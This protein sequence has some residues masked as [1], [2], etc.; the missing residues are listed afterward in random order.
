[1]RGII[2]FGEKGSGK[3]TAA[4]LISS[5]SKK[6]SYFF[7]I[8][9]IVRS[10]SPVF[11]ATDKW[12][13]NKRGF[14][15]DIAKKLKEYDINFLNLFINGKILEKFNCNNFE[16]IKEDKLIIITGGR[17]DEDFDYWKEKG[18]ITV[19]IHCDEEIRQER[20]KNRDGY[21]QNTVDSLEEN[22]K[23]NIKRSDFVIDNSSTKENLENQIATF[24]R[25]L[26][27]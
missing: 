26:Y 3:D 27:R 9:D 11:K 16:E 17:T 20:L 25:E 1:M 7:N 14:F 22:T 8:G 21:F 19:G 18:F 4:T 12:N 15:I 24:V 5:Y 10:M 2:V 6:E 23:N 13:N